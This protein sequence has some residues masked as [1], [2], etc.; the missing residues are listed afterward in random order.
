MLRH[1]IHS[2]IPLVLNINYSSAAAKPHVGLYNCMLQLFVLHGYFKLF[3]NLTPL[4][5]VGLVVAISMY[6]FLTDPV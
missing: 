2:L 4:G 1:S 6:I 3:T 5:R